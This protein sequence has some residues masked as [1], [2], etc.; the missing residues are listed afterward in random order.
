MKHIKEW[1]LKNFNSPNIALY[2]DD[3]TIIICRHS[4]DN[5]FITLGLIEYEYTSDG[6]LITKSSDDYAWK[7]DADHEKEELTLDFKNPELNKLWK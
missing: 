4:S 2:S 6:Y 7:L 3:K 5:T 1:E